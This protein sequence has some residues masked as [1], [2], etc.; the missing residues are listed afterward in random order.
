MPFNDVAWLEGQDNMPGL[1]GEIF[2]IPKSEVDIS[3]LSIA[4]DGVSTIG[5][6]T[7]LP[8]GKITTI[9]ATENTGNITDTDQGEI[10]GKYTQNMLTWFTPGSFPRLE[11]YKRKVRNTPG[12][13]I[14]KD[15]DFNWRLMGIWAARNP[16]YTEGGM[17]DK[18]LPSLDIPARI[19]AINGTQGTRGGDRRGTTFE[20]VQ[21]APHAALFYTGDLPVN[22][23]EGGEV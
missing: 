3:A 9:Y 21:D 14:C 8:E 22:P 7:L 16:L 18:Y 6:I 17:E 4:D 15:T 10:D 11:E 2:F 19:N 23:V 20:V 12:L 1:V 5:N 13:F